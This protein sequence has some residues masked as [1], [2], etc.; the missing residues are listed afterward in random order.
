[1]SK[2]VED[3]LRAWL[4]DIPEP[5][6]RYVSALQLNRECTNAIQGLVDELPELHK[7]FISINIHIQDGQVVH[8]TPV[9]FLSKLHESRPNFPEKVIS[10]LSDG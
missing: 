1:M 4:K 3:K 6:R 2:K 8:P 7:G 9:T 10:G 5:A